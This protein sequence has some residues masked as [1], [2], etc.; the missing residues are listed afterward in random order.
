MVLSYTGARTGRRYRFPIGYFPWGDGEVLSFTSR[1]WPTGLARAT[2]VQLRIRGH[3]V[4]AT[5]DIVGG[6]AD[7][8]QLLRAFADR[9]GPRVAKRLQLGLPGDRQPSDDDLTAA[10]ANTTIIQFRTQLPA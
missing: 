3:V 9:Y 6:H 5:P 4:S 2:D 10:A 7:K 8:M 1:R